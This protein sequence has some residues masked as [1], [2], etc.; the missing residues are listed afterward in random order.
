MASA[1]SRTVTFGDFRQAYSEAYKSIDHWSS[2]LEIADLAPVSDLKLTPLD[3][4]DI[5]RDSA[6]W[7]RTHDMSARKVLIAPVDLTFG[8]AR[9]Y[10]AQASFSA[11]EKVNVVRSREEAA[12]WLEMDPRRLDSFLDGL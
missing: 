7:L 8:M 5:A 10:C 11:Y 12:D 1:Y 2:L 3:L 6:D 9:V 4:R